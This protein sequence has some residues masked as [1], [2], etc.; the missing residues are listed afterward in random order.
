MGD[1]VLIAHNGINF[2]YRFLNK[3]LVQNG[4]EPIKNTLIDTLQL[5]RTLHKDL[6]KHTL[7]A[8]CRK[9]KIEYSDEIAHRADFDAEVLNKV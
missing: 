1:S 8:I 5:S 3:K 2:D 4:F 9:Y 6:F 7:G